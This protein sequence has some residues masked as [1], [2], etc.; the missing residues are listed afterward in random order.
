MLTAIYWLCPSVAERLQTGLASPAIA[1][2]LTTLMPDIEE[3]LAI[4]SLEELVPS[5]ERGSPTGIAKVLMQPQHIG[6]FV[7]SA[8]MKLIQLVEQ[9]TAT[10]RTD[11]KRIRCC[12]VCRQNSSWLEM[13]THATTE[14]PFAMIICDMFEP[15][16]RIVRV[17]K[18]FEDL[19]GYDAESVR[20]LNCRFLQ[21]EDTEQE[22]VHRMVDAIRNALSIQV[23]L[24]NYRKDGSQFKNL[25][26]LR[27]VFDSNGR[28]RYS[29]GIL[30]DVAT[31]TTDLVADV[32]RLC[33]LLPK[34]FESSIQPPQF[35]SINENHGTSGSTPMQS[36]EVKARSVRKRHLRKLLNA[37]LKRAIWCWPNL[38]GWRTS[39]GRC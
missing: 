6:S 38:V 28:Y 25:V 20:G 13:I 32:N 22:A 31:L 26:S 5:Q 30:S 36:V 16:A 35:E 4:E 11:R 18:A 37:R 9:R 21:G 33:R 1:E 19:T 7:E 14:L 10:K 17:N 2:I 34:R 24:T 23:E 15:G 8:G 12:Q 27:P 3:E 39:R 29:I